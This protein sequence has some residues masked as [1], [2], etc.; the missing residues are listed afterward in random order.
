MGRGSYARRRTARTRACSA[1]RATAARSGAPVYGSPVRTRVRRAGGCALALVGGLGVGGCGEEEDHANRERPAASIT[2]TAA[3]VDGRIAVSPRSFG[4]GPVRLIVSNQTR[5]AQEL[6][7]ETGGND[8]GVTQTTDPIT[9]S[10]T[11]TLEVDV[12]EGRYE[13]RTA[14]DEVKPAE[15]RVGAPRESSQNQLLLP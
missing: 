14:D 1:R 4:A 3:I 2:V 12:T 9:P 6:T 7:F 11:A 8:A 10:G 15:V 5:A 13:V